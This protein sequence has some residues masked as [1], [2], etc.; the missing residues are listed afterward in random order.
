[1]RLKILVATLA[2]TL[3]LLTYTPDQAAA[4]GNGKGKGPSPDPA[5]V[6][7]CVQ[8]MQDCFAAG[9]TDDNQCFPMYHKCLGQ[10]GH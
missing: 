5:C 6:A 3:S 7:F 2:I 8:Q 9:G 4:G 10:C 1:M